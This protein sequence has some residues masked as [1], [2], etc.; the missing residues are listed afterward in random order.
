MI[1][2]TGAGLTWV[3]GALAA[4]AYVLPLLLMRGAPAWARTS[5]LLAWGAHGLL[6]SVSLFGW[7]SDQGARFG[8][9]PALSVTAWLVLTVYAV[10]SRL[11]PQLG[12]R[13]LFGGLGALAVLAGVVFP[14]VP[15]H[16]G[17]SMWLPLHAALGVASY[18]LFAAATA[19]AWLMTRTE[20][21]LRRGHVG[22]D[23][24]MPMMTLER[25][26]FVLV[27]AGFMLLSATLLAGWLFGGQLYGYGAGH[28]WH[29]NHKTVFSL[30]SWLVF[31]LLLMGRFLWGWRGKRAIR[32]LYGGAVLLL[33]AYVGSRFVLEVILQRLVLP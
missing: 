25:L 28:A 9:G 29:W 32:F 23:A 33:L 24:G 13:T 14:G 8:F 10:E 6:I 11:Y 15:A 2:P 20:Q 3:L 12:M 27:L 30:L 18:G 21:Q 7:G 16:H 17:S 26:M 5:W 22:E 19:H 1:L 31:A 4:T